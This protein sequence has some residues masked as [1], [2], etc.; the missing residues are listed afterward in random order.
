MHSLRAFALRH[1]W[2]AFSIVFLASFPSASFSL[3]N[4]THTRVSIIGESFNINGVPT[5]AG[6]VWH[7]YRIEGLLF[8]SRMVQGIFDD[9]N[10]QT[11]SRWVYPDTGRWDP[12]R[13]TKEFLAAM[14]DWRSHGLLAF[15]LNLQGGSPEGYSKTQPWVNS[16]F[17]DAGNFRPA[18]TLRL[19]RIIDRADDLGMVVIL[20][21]FYVAQESSLRDDAAVLRATDNAT[22]W[23]LSHGWQ[24][25]MVEIANES[26]PHFHHEILRPDRISEL[27]S[28][29]QAMRWRGHRLLT[30]TSFSGRVIPPESVV[31]ASDFLL[32]HGN[33]IS[34]PEGIASMVRK[35]RE[36]SGYAPKPILFNEDDHYQFDQPRN[37]LTSAI[38]EYAS[39]GYFDYRMAGEGFADGY[40]SVPVDWEISSLRKRAFFKLLMEITHSVKGP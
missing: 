17:D 21:Y 5:Y 29:V 25:V 35:T 15:T 6:C 27:I 39:W 38:S 1:F 13:N 7:G 18:Y 28:R 24:N 14:P 16:A 2:I 26:S 30:G 36:V 12:D 11:V 3:R 32:L 10:P 19:Q 31:R 34:D 40:Q 20:S 4:H 22:R 23:V 37:D 9:L 8:N 33:G